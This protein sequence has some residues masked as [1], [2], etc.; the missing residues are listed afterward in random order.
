M[1]SLRVEHK[2]GLREKNFSALIAPPQV[3]FGKSECHD[4]RHGCGK[5]S[6][7]PCEISFSSQYQPDYGRHYQDSCERETWLQQSKEES[8]RRDCNPINNRLLCVR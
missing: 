2:E 8:V 1:N 3:M 7:L 5:K 4:D 6:H